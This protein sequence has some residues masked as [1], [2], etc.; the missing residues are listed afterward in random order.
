M[1]NTLTPHPGPQSLI[2]R[3][4]QL[5]IQSLIFKLSPG[6]REAPEVPPLKCD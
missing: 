6:V 4:H 5:K 3:Q 2:P 1:Q